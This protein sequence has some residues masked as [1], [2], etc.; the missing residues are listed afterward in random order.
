[1]LLKDNWCFEIPPG[2]EVPAGLD[3][4]QELASILQ[5]QVNAEVDKKFWPVDIT[6]QIKLAYANYNS[7]G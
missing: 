3:V 4:E 6:E 5:Q 7:E 2:Y 1:M